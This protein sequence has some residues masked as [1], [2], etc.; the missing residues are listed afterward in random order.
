ML[1]PD[2][3]AIRAL[4][5]VV[6]HGG[7]A[8][9]AAALHRVQSTVSYQVGKLEAQLGVPLLDRTHYRVQLTPAGEALLAEGRRLL[10]QADR[11][12]WMASRSGRNIIDIVD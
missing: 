2:L 7:F 11:M 12:A 6:R 1:R 4:D 5:A 9:A 10:G 8:Q 3:D